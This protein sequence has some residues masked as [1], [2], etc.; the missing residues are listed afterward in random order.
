M[1]IGVG[2]NIDSGFVVVVGEMGGISFYTWNL[3]GDE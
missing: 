1:A 2:A 3:R